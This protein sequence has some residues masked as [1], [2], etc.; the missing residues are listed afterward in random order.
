[1]LV[2]NLTTVLASKGYFHLKN[3]FPLFSFFL[4]S[5]SG[6][7]YN[8]SCL[9]SP[10]PQLFPDPPFLPYPPDFVSFLFIFFLTNQVQF[11]VPTYCKMCGLNQSV[12]ST[13]GHAVNASRFSFSSSHQCEQLLSQEWVFMPMSPLRAGLSPGLSLHRPPVS[14]PSVSVNS[15]VQLP[16]CVQN[17]SHVII[18]CL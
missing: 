2:S 3:I 12:E 9:Y 17:C 10:L 7:S 6:I 14:C 16:C 13:K 4:V 18:H 1:M 15:S 11:M 5:S 8:A